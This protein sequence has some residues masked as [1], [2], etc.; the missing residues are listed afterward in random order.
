M[1][2]Q[3]DLSRVDLNLLVLF[4]AVFEE[5]HVGRAAGR[6]SLS[7]SA[8]SHGLTRLR[9]LLNDPVFLKTPRGVVPTDRAQALAPMISDALRR[10]RSVVAEAEPFDP[11]TSTRRM[12]IGAPD[13]V[14]AVFLQPLLSDLKASAP[15]IDLGIRQILPI[16]GET[17]PER[18]WSAAFSEIEARALDL[19]VIPSDDAP[20]RFERRLLYEEDFVL[21]MRPDHPFRRQPTIANYCESRHL[22][23]SLTGD[24]HGFVDEVLARDGLSRRVALTVPN[25]MFAAAILS[26]TDLI[27]AIPRRFARLYG[28]R[29]GIAV[30]EPPLPMGQFRLNVF[31]P[32]VALMDDGLAWLIERVL[33]A[34]LSSEPEDRTRPARDSLRQAVPA[35]APLA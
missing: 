27:C 24:P 20:A 1:L 32:K 30:H 31:V 15:G 29:F 7:P 2:N 33:Q 28:D 17:Q 11:A 35:D 21:A 3:T 19:A 22:V 12:V 26:G 9:R 25:F 23:V 10:V 8:V 5:G 14:S 4:E 6:L 13:G 18:A 34:G 16:A